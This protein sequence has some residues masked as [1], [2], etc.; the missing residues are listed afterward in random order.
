MPKLTDYAFTIQ[1]RLAS[2]YYIPLGQFMSVLNK[3]LEEDGLILCP[4]FQRGIV[5]SESQQISYC[6]YVIKGGVNLPIVFNHPGWMSSFEGEMV[7]VDGLQRVTSLCNLFENKLKIF[8]YYLS[9][10]EDAKQVNR[11]LT[12]QF[13]VNNLKKKSEVLAWYLQLN[14]TGMPHTRSE[15]DR[16]ANLLDA[17]IKLESIENK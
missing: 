11:Q 6:E 13:K 17:Q 7:L 8:G 14:S 2:I 5:W 4:D 12:I 9:E 10:F 15:I 3:Y 1:D 16:V